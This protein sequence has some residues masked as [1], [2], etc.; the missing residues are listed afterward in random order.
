MSTY[1]NLNFQSGKEQKDNSLESVLKVSQNKPIESTIFDKDEFLSNFRTLN[2]EE[3]IK[4]LHFNEN[5]IQF[6]KFICFENSHFLNSS[7][8]RDLKNILVEDFIKKLENTKLKK[9][10]KDSN[11]NNRF[12]NNQSLSEFDYLDSTL[13]YIQFTYGDILTPAKL[14]KVFDDFSYGQYSDSQIS[15]KE[16]QKLIY[17]K[18]KRYQINLRE[19]KEKFKSFLR[20]LNK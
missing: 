16:Y 15:E 18:F 14:K 7:S 9:P 12:L 5:E 10:E 6:I 1:D 20:E 2:L 4:L 13:N 19:D 17:N 8:S 3:L 11:M